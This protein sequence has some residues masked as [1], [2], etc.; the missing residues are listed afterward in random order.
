MHGSTLLLVALVFIAAKVG[1]ECALRLKVPSV[2]GE[3]L[4]GVGLGFLA[5]TFSGFPDLLHSAVISEMAEIGV[6]ILLFEVGLES[7]FK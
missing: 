3:L 1:A 5:R 2:V 6:V 4:A 7:T